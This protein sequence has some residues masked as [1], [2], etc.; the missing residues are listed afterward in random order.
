MKK[1]VL[2][3]AGVSAGVALA[4]TLGI[5][6]IVKKIKKAKLDKEL[7]GDIFNVFDTQ[8]MKEGVC[9]RNYHCINCSYFRDSAE[10]AVEDDGTDTYEVEGD[11]WTSPEEFHEACKLDGDIEDDLDCFMET[12]DDYN[13]D[14]DLVD[15]DEDDEYED[16]PDSYYEGDGFG[17][18]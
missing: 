16:Y 13:E 2:L 14:D 18:D 9:E 7:S 17:E 6:S 12:E 15:E 11:F 5:I 4:T 3:I 8:C 10:K 1:K